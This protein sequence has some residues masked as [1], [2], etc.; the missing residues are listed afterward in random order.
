MGRD[1]LHLLRRTNLVSDP[2][3]HESSS[4]TL[5]HQFDEGLNGGK[6]RKKKKAGT[7]GKGK[8]AVL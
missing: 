4:L 8:D 7:E 1:T 6:K 3:L 2:L 5:Q